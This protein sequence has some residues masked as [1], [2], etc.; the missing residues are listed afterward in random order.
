[1]FVDSGVLMAQSRKHQPFAGHT[2]AKSEKD[3]KR[4]ASRRIRRL[5]R[6]IHLDETTDRLDTRPHDGGWTFAKDG[7]GRFDPNESPRLL[8]K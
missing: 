2:T 4:R 8:R 3:D 1:M 7:R 5:L 6:R